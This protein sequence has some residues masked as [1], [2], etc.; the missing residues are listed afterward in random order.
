MKC[1]AEDAVPECAFN[2]ERAGN[3]AL[4]LRILNQKLQISDH[5]P[6]KT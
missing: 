1:I 4:F 2:D 5:Q 3:S 6:N